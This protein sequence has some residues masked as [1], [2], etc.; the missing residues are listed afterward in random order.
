MNFKCN[1]P[2]ASVLATFMLLAVSHP[3]MAVDPDGTC[4]CLT[5]NC[6]YTAHCAVTASTCALLSGNSG[7][8]LHSI[9]SNLIEQKRQKLFIWVGTSLR[10]C[11]LGGGRILLAAAYHTQMTVH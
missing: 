2:S 4:T 6:M 11:V 9:L 7:H 3:A 10:T 8:R 1:L 5:C